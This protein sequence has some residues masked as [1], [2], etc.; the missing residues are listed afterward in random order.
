MTLQSNFR[1][2]F[3]QFGQSVGLA[4][5]DVDAYGFAALQIDGFSVHVA[6]MAEAGEA[7]LT[8]TVAPLPANPSA[9]FLTW[10]LGESLQQ[11]ELR[12]MALAVD[13]EANSVVLMRRFS[14]NGLTVETLTREI[15]TL[16]SLVESAAREIKAHGAAAQPSDELNPILRL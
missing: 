7:M 4:S 8:A 15:E 10:L 5:L 1:L 11:M 2:V 16:A 9:A 12:G 14:T 3:S 13:M 6:H